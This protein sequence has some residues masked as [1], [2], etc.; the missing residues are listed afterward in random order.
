MRKR[1]VVESLLWKG[2]FEKNGVEK[3]L[4]KVATDKLNRVKSEKHKSN[5]ELVYLSVKSH[6]ED[7]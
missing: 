5:F 6:D 7:M 4:L 1:S 3:K 2:R